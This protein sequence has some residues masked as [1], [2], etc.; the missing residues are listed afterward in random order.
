[1]QFVCHYKFLPG[2]TRHE[3][4]DAFLRQVDSGEFEPHQIQSWFGCAD[5]TGGTLLIECSNPFQLRNSLSGFS[6]V[7]QWTVHPAY[8]NVFTQVLQEIESKRSVEFDSKQ[9]FN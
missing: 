4:E 3:I 7:I 1:M 6:D 2:V 8:V 9:E 5:G